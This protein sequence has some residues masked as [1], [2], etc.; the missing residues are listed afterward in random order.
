MASCT[1][2][3]I[4]TCG[5]LI[6][7]QLLYPAE[8]R[9]HFIQIKYYY[10]SKEKLRLSTVLYQAVF[11]NFTV[12]TEI[13]INT[14]STHTELIMN[15][16]VANVLNPSFFNDF[17][18]CIYQVDGSK[19][20]IITGNGRF[21][22]SG[23]DLFHINDFNRDEIIQFM[24]TFES[25]LKSVLD[26]KGKTIAQINGHTIAGGF[27]LA[28]ACDI[29]YCE[30]GA[31]KL[32]MNEEKLGIK[33]PPL[34]QAI[35]QCTFGDD[36]HKLLCKDDFYIPEEMDQFNHFSVHEISFEDVT[37]NQK[38]LEK[39]NQFMKIEKDKQLDIFLNSWFS[40]KSIIAR[41]AAINSLKKR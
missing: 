37:K 17:S 15:H 13:K 26:R 20:L 31:Y 11:V 4:R 23:L 29:V 7:S 24:A 35:I 40:E 39:I 10:L 27:I 30:P 16:S 33:L 32:G 8:L 34:A 1:L 25:M 41:N 2:D 5:L 22:S 38:R 9:G 36:I 12:N 3:R 14:F 28:T 21:F 18:K 6:R 19:N